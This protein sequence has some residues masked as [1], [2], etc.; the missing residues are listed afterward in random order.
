MIKW[1]IGFALAIILVGFVLD[2]YSQVIVID[3]NS[4]SVKDIILIPLPPPTR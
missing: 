4:G 2:A 1:I 3:P